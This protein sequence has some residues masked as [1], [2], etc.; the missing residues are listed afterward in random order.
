MLDVP[1]G[2][3]IRMSDDGFGSFSTERAVYSR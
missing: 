2:S 3:P 1:D